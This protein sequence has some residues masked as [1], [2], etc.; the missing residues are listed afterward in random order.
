MTDDDFFE[1]MA[2]YK[3]RFLGPGEKDEFVYEWKPDVLK[4]NFTDAIEALADVAK[5]A[6]DEARFPRQHL[7]LLLEYAAVRRAKRL[8]IS[9]QKPWG[10]RPSSSELWDRRML[11]IGAIE[12][13]EFN[14]RQAERKGS[15]A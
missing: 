11:E 1:W 9:N 10:P 6:N 3:K 2:R 7:R 14:R 8:G 5:D 12:T 13:E 4:L 15:A